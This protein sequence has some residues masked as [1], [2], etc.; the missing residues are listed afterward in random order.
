[1]LHRLQIVLGHPCPFTGFL[2]GSFVRL[3]HNHFEGLERPMGLQKLFELLSL[4]RSVMVAGQLAATLE[5]DLNQPGHGHQVSCT[6]PR[7]AGCT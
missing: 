6:R 5:H 1:M 7:L 3:T 4:T 2:E